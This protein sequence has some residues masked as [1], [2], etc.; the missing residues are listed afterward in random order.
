LTW[1]ARHCGTHRTSTKAL[2]AIGGKSA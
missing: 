1:A 2:T